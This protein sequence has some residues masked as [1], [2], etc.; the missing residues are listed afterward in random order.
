[1][2]IKRNSNNINFYKNIINIIFNFINTLRNICDNYEG[3]NNNNI[4]NAL[5][6][7]KKN[8]YHS[9][10]RMTKTKNTDK[11]AKATPVVPVPATASATP[12]AQAVVAKKP[13]AP[14]VVAA[15]APVEVV[16]PVAVVASSAVASS[17]V[18]SSAEST[19]AVASDA[20][21]LDDGL[22][23]AFADAFTK[24]QQVTTMLSTLK[25]DFRQLEKRAMRELKVANKASAK[26]RRKSGNRSPSGFVKPT[27]ISEELASFLGKTIGTEMARTEV[28][29]EINAYIRKHNLQDKD[30]GRKINPDAGLTSLLKLKTDDE[31]TYF[32]LQ[33]YMSPHFAKSVKVLQAASAVAVEAM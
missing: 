25:T 16:V 17:A 23:L 1:L 33:R 7:L 28:T 4:Y 15:V 2:Y 20:V 8:Y 5:N 32:N 27:L 9:V 26:R 19:E 6:H 31:L 22:V 13:R 3:I 21:S 11:V 29:R 14:K 10:Y 18:A 30:N 12:V 24:L